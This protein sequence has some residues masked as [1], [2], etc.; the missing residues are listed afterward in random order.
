MSIHVQR[1]THIMKQADSLVAAKCWLAADELHPCTPGANIEPHDV[2]GTHT[3]HHIVQYRV[4]ST[5]HITYLVQNVIGDGG[6]SGWQKNLLFQPS[7]TTPLQAR[8]AHK[9]SSHKC[10]P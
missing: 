7:P 3:T 4:Q 2:V 8:T 10:R 6:C 5:E 9:R 1:D